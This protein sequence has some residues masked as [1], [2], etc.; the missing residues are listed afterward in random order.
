MFAEYSNTGLFIAFTLLIAE[1]YAYGIMANR[2]S[3]RFVISNKSEDEC[4]VFI[5]KSISSERMRA[6]QWCYTSIM[7]YVIH[8]VC[9]ES[10][11]RSIYKV[12]DIAR[13]IAPVVVSSGAGLLTSDKGNDNKQ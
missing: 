6:I 3:D 8:G 1:S 2:E 11:M 12:I 4:S 10:T 5:I 7:V 9:R 13:C